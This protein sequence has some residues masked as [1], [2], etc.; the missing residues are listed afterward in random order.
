MDTWFNGLDVDT[1]DH[2]YGL[3]KQK[4]GFL[5]RATPMAAALR[6]MISVLLHS[7]GFQANHPPQ[8]S[9]KQGIAQP[10]SRRAQCDEIT[11]FVFHC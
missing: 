7:M 4:L 1:L 5:K 8:H 2:G 11:R 6:A 9:C 3:A 10:A